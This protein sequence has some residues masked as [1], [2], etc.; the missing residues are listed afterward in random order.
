MIDP[1]PSKS[2]VGCL[3]FVGLK[4]S[5]SNSMCLVFVEAVLV[6]SRMCLQN[7]KPRPHQVNSWG[8]K[9]SVHEIK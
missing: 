3:D 4:L 2:G 9:K 8:I 7:L 6:F 5:C 1:G